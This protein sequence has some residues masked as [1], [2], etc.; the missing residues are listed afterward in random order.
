MSTTPTEW[1]A[2]SSVST[3]PVISDSIINSNSNRILRS[4]RMGKSSKGIEIKKGLKKRKCHS[5]GIN[6]EKR[7]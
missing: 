7:F 5:L 3:V 2:D 4:R 6:L 1:Q